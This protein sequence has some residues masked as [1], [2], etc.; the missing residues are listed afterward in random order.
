MSTKRCPGFRTQL[1]IMT[2]KAQVLATYA[3][4]LP[5]I[6]WLALTYVY[7]NSTDSVCMVFLFA[8]FN[9]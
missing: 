2:H 4:T 8:A 5:H 9:Q 6:E 1:I 3:P 7:I